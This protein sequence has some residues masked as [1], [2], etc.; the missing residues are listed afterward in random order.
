MKAMAS[1][2]FNYQ[3][4]PGTIVTGAADWHSEDMLGQI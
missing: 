4:L 2:Y 3:Y 1:F